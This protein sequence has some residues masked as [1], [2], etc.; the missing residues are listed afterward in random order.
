MVDSSVNLSGSGR[1]RRPVWATPPQ[2]LQ[3]LDDPLLRG[4][5]LLSPT[6]V[7][8]HTQLPGLLKQPSFPKSASAP[9]F[10]AAEKK[11]VLRPLEHRP[12]TS[13]GSDVSVPS[14]GTACGHVLVLRCSGAR[15]FCQP[16]Y[17]AHELPI[18]LMRGMNA[19]MP[20]LCSCCCVRHT[21]C[22]GSRATLTQVAS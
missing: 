19:A 9:V 2:P 21:R 15:S 16:F 3:S 12:S 11:P 8:S 6:V 13:A 17:S 1:L 20:R 22:C 14:R 7:S 18:L 4:E 10:P 5:A